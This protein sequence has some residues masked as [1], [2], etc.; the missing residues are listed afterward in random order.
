M[1]WDLLNEFSPKDLLTFP[2]G[3]PDSYAI[4]LGF[5]ARSDHNLVS[6]TDTLAFEGW[7][8]QNLA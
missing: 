8:T 6:D 5:I 3:G 2:D 4:F 1:I 7:V